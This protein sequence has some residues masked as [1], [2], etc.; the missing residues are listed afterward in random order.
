MKNRKF[1]LNKQKHT[2]HKQDCQAI[3]QLMENGFSLMESLRVIEDTNNKVVLQNIFVRLRQGESISTI[4]TNYC[5]KAY[6]TY[7]SCFILYM[8]FLDALATSIHIVQQEE[9]NQKQIL[10]GM[11]YPSLLFVAM[12]LGIYMFN[13]WIMPNMM[14]LM[15]GFDV[16]ITFYEIL[17]LVLLY[18]CMGVLVLLGVIVIFVI[19]ALQKNHIVFTYQWISK[20]FPQNILVQ[21]V[22]EQF[23]R[24]F[25]ECQKRNISTKNT[26]TILSQLHE[27]PCV[28]FI[29]QEMD[30]SLNVGIGMEEAMQKTRIE[31][32]LLQFFRIAFYASDTQAMLEG[33]LS[34]VAVRKQKAIRTYTRNIQCI[35]YSCIGI[36][37]IFVYRILMIPMTMLQ[38]L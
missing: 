3:V 19:I 12:L 37:L 15:V 14:Q 31:K 38:S 23:A 5:P 4:F 21:Y 16:D 11:L 9:A 18:G 6:Q 27:K 33:Y 2:L 20:Y 26:C 36:V 24:F 13:V 1:L 28:A 17:H 29:A 35:S 32:A 22:S 30:K 34:M 8:P 10:S 25:L 7:F